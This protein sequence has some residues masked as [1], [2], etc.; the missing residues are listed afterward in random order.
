[1]KLQQRWQELRE[2]E[3]TAKEHNRQLLQQFDE[4]QDR[5][6][7]M[8]TLNAT[9]KTIRVCTEKTQRNT[10]YAVQKTLEKNLE[11]ELFFYPTL[12]MRALVLFP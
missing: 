11:R 12:H 4:A 5:L 10:K 8:L 1:M 7:D 9:M 3:L 6:R 2:R